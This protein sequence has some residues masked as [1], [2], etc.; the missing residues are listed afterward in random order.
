MGSHTLFEDSLSTGAGYVMTCCALCGR[1]E[2]MVLADAQRL[3]DDTYK[4]AGAKVGAGGR[5]RKI[6]LLS[7]L[8]LPVWDTVQARPCRTCRV[9]P[10]ESTTLLVYVGQLHIPRAC[11]ALFHFYFHH[12]LAFTFCSSK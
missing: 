10:F 12:D 7:G 2:R 4:A 6:A 1:Y 8:V 9:L 3:W 5:V 11:P